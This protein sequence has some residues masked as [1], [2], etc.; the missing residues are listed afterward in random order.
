MGEFI[1]PHD[2]PY[3]AGIDLDGVEFSEKISMKQWLTKRNIPAVP[4][5][6]IITRE[7]IR[8]PDVNTLGYYTARIESTRRES[9][10]EELEK[11][12]FPDLP[13]V[14]TSNSPKNKVERLVIDGAAKKDDQ[15]SYLRDDN[16]VYIPRETVKR[17]ILIDNSRDKVLEGFDKL[18][19]EKPDL[20]L[21]L[22][23]F[24]LLYFYDF[25]TG[26][27]PKG[28]VDSQTPVFNM[29]GWISLKEILGEFRSLDVQK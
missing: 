1:R 7:L 21:L 27:P 12:R 14:H 17:V 11:Y 10:L 4:G 25:T 3:Q 24:T 6:Q 23:T 8:T 5:A 26:R 18:L 2:R 19:K 15:D 28:P 9:T 16:G 29:N 13:V 20:A 22:S